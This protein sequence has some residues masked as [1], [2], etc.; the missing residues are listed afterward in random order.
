MDEKEA[1]D[2]QIQELFERIE[3]LW[4]RLEIEA[5]YIEQFTERNVGSGL[6]SIQAVR[7]PPSSP[8]NGSTKRS[9]NASWRSARPRC[10]PS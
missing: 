3:P 9:S 8:A 2:A 5:E 4:V 7:S 6:A 1:R 10:R